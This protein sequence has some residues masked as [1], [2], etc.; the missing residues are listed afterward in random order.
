V[1]VT[2]NIERLVIDGAEF[3]GLSRQDLHAAVAG[4]L[5]R[6]ISSEGVGGALLG[7]GMTPGWS[8][9]PIRATRDA[10]DLGTQIARAVHRSLRSPGNDRRR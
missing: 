9:E 7:G 3:E 6:L 1:N 2:L 5:T 8:T 10:G 4:E